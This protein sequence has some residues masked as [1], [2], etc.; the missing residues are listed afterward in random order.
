[1][2]RIPTVDDT[3]ATGLT[4]E[5]IDQAKQHHGGVLPGI[6]KV[7]LVDLKLAGLV[8][9]LYQHLNFRTD[10]PLTRLQREMVATVVNGTIGGAP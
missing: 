9:E 2:A 3:Q 7:L 4:K 5:I 8:G 10:S 1:M 6:Y